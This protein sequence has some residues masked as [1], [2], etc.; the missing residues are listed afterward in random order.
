MT[1]ENFEN[2]VSLL[3][4]VMGLIYCCFK[5]IDRPRRGYAY[6]IGFF[7]A[8]F[9]GEYYWAIYVIITHSYPDVSELL[10]YLGWNIAIVFLLLA[11]VTMRSEKAKR[12]FHPVMLLPILL[13]IP[14]CKLGW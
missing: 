14:Q 5:Y 1:L 9:V 13:N 4:V 8:F 10:T 6:L 11:V 3:C 2:I 7:L 12:Y